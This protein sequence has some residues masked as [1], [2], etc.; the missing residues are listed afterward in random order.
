MTLFF[1]ELKKIWNLPTVF[2]LVI[3]M[4]LNFSEKNLWSQAISDTQAGGFHSVMVELSEKFG[5]T[6][7]EDEFPEVK[8]ILA[9]IERELDEI[10]QNHPDYETNLSK[11]LDSFLAH[12]YKN[13]Q[14]EGELD[15]VALTEYIFQYHE[16]LFLRQHNYTVVVE[17]YE[18][19]MANPSENRY[20]FYSEEQ[21][22]LAQNQWNG[23]KGRSFMPNDLV[24]ITQGTFASHFFDTFSYIMLLLLPTIVRDRKNH[25]RD[26]QWSSVTGR[27][28]LAWQFMAHW[29]TALVFLLLSPVM[30][31][32]Y[33]DMEIIQY[34]WHHS[35]LYFHYGFGYLLDF[36]YIQLLVCYMLFAFVLGLVLSGIIFL[37]SQYSP[38]YPSLL[39][40]A[41]P[42]FYV[43]YAT[44]E[45]WQ[46][47]FSLNDRQ[48]IRFIL[49]WSAWLE[50][51]LLLF[52]VVFLGILTVIAFYKEKTCDLLEK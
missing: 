11:D 12:R 42:L 2:L 44:E 43:I 15:D 13:I 8:A 36:T 18:E 52:A 45:A 27:H 6:L 1:M 48:I 4:W 34:F 37:L 47:L 25:L 23:G 19:K 50:V 30:F 28:I 10:I 33:F 3:L 22:E 17:S 40:K 51:Y 14:R 49:P 32:Y 39:L 16:T 26:L 35:V 21:K 29:A 24:D 31:L 38:H 41:I 46:R 20:V 7:E 9:D 5:K